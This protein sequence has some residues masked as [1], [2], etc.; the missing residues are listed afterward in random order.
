MHHYTSVTSKTF[1]DSPAQK[2]AWQEDI[3]TIA[4]DAEYL[5]DAILAVSALHL[6]ALNPS[7][8]SVVR[9]SHGYMASALAKFSSLLKDGVSE[10]NAEALFSTAALIGKESDVII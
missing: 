4:Y 7:D 5:M 1:S 3:P 9:A 6:R 10:L 8:R 2:V